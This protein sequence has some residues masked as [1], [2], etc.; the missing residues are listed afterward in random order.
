MSSALNTYEI[1]LVERSSFKITP[2]GLSNKTDEGYALYYL[3]AAGKEQMLEGRAFRSIDSLVEAVVL[4]GGIKYPCTITTFSAP[5]IR[6]C[7]DEN[8]A[9]RIEEVSAS[10]LVD[11]SHSLLSRRVEKSKTI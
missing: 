2:S 4:N 7:P 8:L 9:F 6:L 3:G 11:F 10:V 5:A 1:Y